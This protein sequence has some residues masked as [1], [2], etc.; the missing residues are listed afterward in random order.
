TWD[1]EPNPAPHTRDAS[2]DGCDHTPTSSTLRAPRKSKRS[3]AGRAA[4]TPP[5]RAG[6]W[7]ISITDL[8]NPGPDDMVQGRLPQEDQHECRTRRAPDHGGNL[9]LASFD[10]ILHGR[11]PTAMRD[12]KFFDFFSRLQGQ[13]PHDPLKQRLSWNGRSFKANCA[14][15]TPEDSPIP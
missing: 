9:R 15:S 6:S 2:P 8:G 7:R 11:W 1:T 13:L 14:A 10:S 4:R 5:A 3:C 12:P